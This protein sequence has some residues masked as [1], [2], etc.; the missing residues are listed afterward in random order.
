MENMPPDDCQR[1]QTFSNLQS[2]LLSTEED[3]IFAYGFALGMVMMTDVM[4]EA[5]TIIEN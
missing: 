1:F 4:K 2:E 5:E 3:N